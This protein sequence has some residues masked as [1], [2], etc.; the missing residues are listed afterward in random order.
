MTTADPTAVTEILR[1]IREGDTGE[2]QT[3]ISVVYEDLKRVAAKALHGEQGDGTPSSLVHE[4]FERLVDDSNVPW[5]DRAHFF[6]VA[7]REMRRVL[8][9]RARREGALKRGGGWQRI[10]LVDADCGTDDMTIELLAL[11]EALDDV[12]RRKPRHQQVA[13]LRLFGEMTYKEIGYVLGYSEETIKKDWQFVRAWL[14]R[15][16]TGGEDA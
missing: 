3:L 16:L 5:E 1:R 12:G 7:A 2:V 4:T 9:D 11:A 15:V 8:V 6:A 10:S 13:E 14:R